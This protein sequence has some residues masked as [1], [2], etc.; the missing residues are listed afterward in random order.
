MNTAERRLLVLACSAT[1]R[2]DP[3]RIHALLRYDGPSARVVR[4]FLQHH[5]S[6]ASRLTIAILSAEYGL[7]LAHDP[8]PAYNR[9][10]TPARARELAPDVRAA[11]AS[12]LARRGPF[13]DSCVCAGVN[14]RLALGDLVGQ[15]DVTVT[16]GGIGQQ[17]G[18]LKAWLL[19]PCVES[20]R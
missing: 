19:R 11:L 9:L 7:I 5:P 20:V 15:P 14:Y 17:L 2:S 8:I 16:S 10:M 18:Q 3:G 12:L 13:G 6:E 4:H 1:K